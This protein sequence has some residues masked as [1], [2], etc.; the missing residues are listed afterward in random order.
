MALA[1]CT[2]CG[3]FLALL[4]SNPGRFFWVISAAASWAV[5]PTIPACTK[6]RYNECNNIDGAISC[7]DFCKGAVPCIAATANSLCLSCGL[8]VI[9]ETE[10][11]KH[12]FLPYTS[13]KSLTIDFPLLCKLST[14]LSD[15]FSCFPP[16]RSAEGICQATPTQTQMKHFKSH[17]SMRYMAQSLWWF[18]QFELI[19][20]VQILVK[21]CH[22]KT[23]EAIVHGT[24][25]WGSQDWTNP[26]C[27][28]M[29]LLMRNLPRYLLLIPGSRRVLHTWPTREGGLFWY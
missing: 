26:N 23:L 7:F 10:H 28:E 5:R 22:Y 14:M 1:T 6:T 3:P 15:V 21:S 20:Q 27:S 16:T 9:Q 17:C 12:S 11:S 29:Y 19:P 8:H 25:K 4:S 2:L 24:R 13:P 18:F